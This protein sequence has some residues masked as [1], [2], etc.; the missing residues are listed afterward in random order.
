MK[1]R[2]IL[3]LI[4]VV[5]FVL[6]T[7]TYSGSKN[8]SLPVARAEVQVKIN[9]K[10]VKCQTG[11]DGH[12]GLY[13][14][15]IN[16]IQTMGPDINVFFTVRPPKNFRQK[17]QDKRAFIRVSKSEG[18]YFELVL[19]FNPETGKFHIERDLSVKSTFK[20]DKGDATK[21]GDKYMGT[22][23]HF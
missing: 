13:F 5:V 14:S 11:D 18:P 21:V 20:R 1:N 7:L 9:N 2:R 10:E 8:Q 22:V 4:I 3:T 6:T 17:V 19:L 23:A 15:D 16:S 12:F